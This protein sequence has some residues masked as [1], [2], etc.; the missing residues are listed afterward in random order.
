MSIWYD[1]T[2]LY[3]SFYSSTGFYFI[4]FYLRLFSMDLKGEVFMEGKEAESKKKKCCL[5]QG[6]VQAYTAL[7]STRCTSANCYRSTQLSLHAGSPS[8]L[9]YCHFLSGRRSSLSSPWKGATV[10]SAEAQGSNTGFYQEDV[11]LLTTA[12]VKPDTL[13]AIATEQ[14]TSCREASAQVCWQPEHQ[15]SLWVSY[16]PWS[17]AL[18]KL[19]G[20]SGSFLTG[21][22]ADLTHLEM[23]RAGVLHKLP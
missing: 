5:L 3:H 11:L 16:F 8:R 18:E 2:P 17:L 13:P 1:C 14:G 20:A 21:S 19:A 10:T 15:Q 4:L 22:P 6:T 12:L 7:P 23:P 9:I